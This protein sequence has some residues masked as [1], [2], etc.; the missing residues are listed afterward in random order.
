[1]EISERKDLRGANLQ[2]ANLQWFNLEK[3]DLDGAN[4]KGADLFEANLKGADHRF[5]LTKKQFSI[6]KHF[7]IFITLADIKLLR[8]TNASKESKEW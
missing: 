6:S 3:A 7:N 1:M 5:L 2:G 4:L 8:W